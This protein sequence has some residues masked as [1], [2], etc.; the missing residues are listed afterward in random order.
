MFLS[1][2]YVI[3]LNINYLINGI[4]YYL[5]RTP[6]IKRIL[7][8]SLL[9]NKILKLIVTILAYIVTFIKSIINKILYLSILFIFP[10]MEMG[11]NS[12]NIENTITILFFTTLS[13]AMTNTKFF[14][15]T[16]SK[17]YGVVLLN[18]DAKKYNLAE[19][20]IYII[21]LFIG[22][23]VGG[24]LVFIFNF[25][26]SQTILLIMLFPIFTLAIKNIYIA[27]KLYFY[28][29]YNKI[30]KDENQL[31]KVGYVVWVGLFLIPYIL[32]YLG[33]SISIE[34]ITTTTILSLIINIW[35]I[36]EIIK[37]DD[38]RYITK[39]IYKG[40]NQITRKQNGESL[41]KYIYEDKIDMSETS[42]KNGHK[43]L[44]DIFIK[45]HKKILQ[46]PAKRVAVISTIL[47]II[48]AY[49]I[50]NNN[51]VKGLVS[52]Y[53]NYYLTS[54]PLIMY[55]TNTG[56]SVVV[57]MYKNC[58]NSLLSYNFY[59]KSSII[60]ETFRLRL[61]SL[62]KINMI[63]TIVIAIGV[64]ML[65]YLAQPNTQKYIYIYIILSIISITI[66]F[67]IH[68]LVIYYL[69]QPYDKELKIKSFSYS[70]ITTITYILC[71][72]INGKSI[73]VETFAKTSIIFTLVY[74]V[75]SMILVY[76]FA[77]KTFKN[78]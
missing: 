21:E 26:K 67:S 8:S 17:Y 32:I 37:F 77:P 74:I 28:R 41:Y 45:R 66:F 60:L 2:K 44:N 30:I 24:F 12:L 56:K 35:A 58:D 70:L 68:Y 54:L 40:V 25:S 61:I 78:R 15:P 59:K 64:S 55:F 19:Y 36:R 18:M 23:I 6:I 38:Y 33:V 1:L 3:K 11:N 34:I 5:K 43:Y 4:F 72:F 50:N 20:L 48:I 69:L 76:K 10:M 39:E 13:G 14:N 27:Q 46:K 53:I 47:F 73:P 29:K 9:D 57:Y 65:L 7:P 63:Y 75:V 71:L 49:Y 42:N 22:Y 31:S 52:E 16:T 62:V 51:E